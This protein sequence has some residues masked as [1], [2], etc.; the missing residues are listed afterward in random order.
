M[1][2]HK[3]DVVII[4]GGISGCAIAYNL[5]KKG[6]HNVI[7]VEKN[8]IASGATGRCGAGIRQQWGTEMNCLIAKKS[9]EAFQTAQDELDYP[10]DIEFK[11]GGYLILSTSEEENQ[12][13]RE[14]VV[15][16]NR[17]DIPSQFLT[18]DEACSIVP[19]LN[20]ES[21]H[22]AT[23][24]PT[25]G[26]LN[27]FLA[28]DAY[29]RASKRLGV[30][31]LLH[32]PVTGI[33]MDGDKVKGVTTPN[34]K[35]YAPIVVN[36]AGG[37]SKEVSQLAGH[38]LPVHSE[39]HEIL[40][41]EPIEAML[42]PMVMSF[43]MNIYC[44]QTPHGSFIMGRGDDKVSSMNSTSTWRFLDRMADTVTHLL[45]PVGE[46]RVIRQWAGL[47]NNTQDHQPI[48]GPVSNIEGYYLAVGYSGHGFMFGPMTG[49]LM[50]EYIMGEPL[51]ID[52]RSLSIDRFNSGQLVYE[53]SFV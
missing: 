16:Q 24:C 21:V 35:I 52:I 5:A 48:L 19:Y 32:T 4:G 3:A 30:R 13:F 12:Q 42:D 15:L 6:I 43:S 25:D 9:I 27:P 31:F 8:F 10:Y 33:L 17:L 44:Q 22:G 7:V 23:F 26:H 39:R 49:L 41:T 47:Y 46:L 20:T 29:Y 34:E 50:A 40:V 18:P 45:P 51:S 53:K 38:N 37:Q 36:A 14:N 1:I 11:Q 2:M 28:T